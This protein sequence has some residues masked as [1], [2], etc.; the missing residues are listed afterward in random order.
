MHL[1]KTPGDTTESERNLLCQLKIVQDYPGNVVFVPGN[2]DWDEG[3]AGGLKT[4]KTEQQY[5]EDYRS[6]MYPDVKKIP[7][8]FKPTA[9]KPGPESYLISPGIRM[10]ALDTQWFLHFYKKDNLKDKTRKQTAEAFYNGLDS[11]LNYCQTHNEKALLVYHHPLFTNGGHGARKQPLRFLINYTP[12][13]LL[14]LIGGNRYFVQD[15]PQPRFKKMRN[16]MLAIM[17]K[18]KGVINASGHEHY[19]QHY[20][21]GDDHFIVSGSGSKLSHK[22]VDIYKED[23]LKTSNPAL[24][25][26]CFM[27]MAA[28][29]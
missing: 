20:T 11:L 13:Q 18:Y 26:L 27:L 1:S 19:L 2:H 28:P 22:K 24:P 5:I 15:I 23:F 8:L 21:H 17:G 16:R 12:F 10:I 9:G 14:G 4:I 3:K 29:K 6:K 25:S 7:I